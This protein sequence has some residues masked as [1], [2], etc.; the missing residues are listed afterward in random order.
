MVTFEQQ[1][2]P[3]SNP[4]N[5]ALEKS[6]PPTFWLRPAPPPGSLFFSAPRP[7][8]PSTP[9]NPARRRRFRR[10]RPRGLPGVRAPGLAGLYWP[11]QV[12]ADSPPPRALGGSE[13]IQN[14]GPS[15]ARPV[16]R[17]TL[18][19]VG[20]RAFAVVGSSKAVGLLMRARGGAGLGGQRMDQ[21]AAVEC[22][23]P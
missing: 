12:A 5:T 9:A 21:T 3:G 13:A 16:R 20:S 7:R 23:R 11:E 19:H 10:M 17:C 4:L 1:R 18:Q 15:D 2:V 8:R 14:R 6:A 22:M